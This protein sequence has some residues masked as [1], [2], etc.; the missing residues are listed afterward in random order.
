MSQRVLLT[1]AGGSVGSFLRPM[2][3]E[4]YGETIL[5]DR[6]EVPDLAPGESFRKASLD[7]AASMLAAC[8]GVDGIIHLGGQSVE[9]DW[10]TIDAANVNGL[11]TMFEA[12]RQAGVKRVIFASSN[13]AVGM[14]P[15]HRRIGTGEKVRPD[16]F[17]GLSK[18]FGEAM[19]ALYADKHA[20]RCLSIR[21]GN[22]SL[23]PA[24]LRRLSIWLHPEDLFQLCVIGLEHPD[25]HNEI[26][27]GASD[28]ARSF[29]DN[30]TA[31][32]LGYRPKHRAEDHVDHAMSEQAK[33]SGDPIGDRLQG[34][35]FCSAGWNGDLDRTLWR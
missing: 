8:E 24:D 12:A 6:A 32:D 23:R 13:H 26:V 3:L 20:M 17:Y 4:R 35:T 1:G 33:I 34:G 29:W 27:F 16:T 21:I 10:Q 19:C 25:L 2:L 14:Y 28:N 9:A 18:A 31:F 22:V 15:R 5:S 30:R 7:D 11:L